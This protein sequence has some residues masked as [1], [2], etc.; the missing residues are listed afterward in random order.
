MDVMKCKKCGIEKQLDDFGK[1]KERGY[2][3]YCLDCRKEY[4]KKYYSE[5]RNNVKVKV[6][7]RSNK[8]REE[9]INYINDV[10]KNGC[11]FCEEK[12]IVCMDFHHISDKL[13]N[14]SDGIKRGYSL[15]KIKTEI[16]K[17]IMLCSNCHRKLHAGL[18]TTESESVV[19]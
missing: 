13:F 6:R 3:Y 2:Q 17:C 1:H 9:N 4:D 11:C 5:N 8:R 19:C 12:E 7:E 10:K 18:I 15:N 14:I 16:D